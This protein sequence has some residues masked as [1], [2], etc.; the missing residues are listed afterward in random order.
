MTPSSATNWR[1][2][3]PVARLTRPLVHFLHIEASGGIVLLGATV[4]ALIAANTPWAADYASFWEQKFEIRIGGVGLSYPLWYWINDGLMAIF[5]FVI[6]LE[7]KRELVW[8]ELRD[9]RNI[10]LPAVAALGGAAVP[11]TLYLMLQGDLPGSAGWA[12]PMATDIAFVVGCMAILGTRVPIGLKVFVLSLA[13]I[14]DILAVIVI[15]AFFTG[16]LKLVWL[17]GALG[18]LAVIY[19]LNRGGV[20]RISVY[21]VPG[22]FIWLCT[23]KGG[24]HPTVAGALLGLLTPARAWVGDI[25]LLEVVRSAVSRIRSTEDIGPAPSRRE[26]AMDLSL[27]ATESVSPLERLEHGLHPWVSFVIMPVFALANAAVPISTAGLAHPVS[28]AV[29]VGL[30]I[31]KPLGI[32]LTSWLVVRFGWARL[33]ASTSWTALIGAGSL[34]GIGFTMALFIASLSLEG[35]VLTAAKSGILLG[36]AVSL[37]IGISLLFAASRKLNATGRPKASSTHEK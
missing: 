35:I 1:P 13:I 17:A 34:A 19:L 4:L 22:A 14:D 8:G 31:G 29:I 25:T 33:P 23:L 11:V 3:T 7:I 24:I 28:M 2:S 30:V 36:S 9:P 12:V 5:F 32:A 26:A 16:S 10:V 37:L 20:R 27:A 18:G 21:V 15:A 6:G